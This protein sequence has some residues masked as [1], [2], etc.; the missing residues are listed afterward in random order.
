M[1]PWI[2]SQGTVD[3]GNI[4]LKRGI[5]NR[6]ERCC[7]EAFHVTIKT[8]LNEETNLDEKN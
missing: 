7:P 5:P 4:T 2:W 8:D 1:H 6:V 3:K